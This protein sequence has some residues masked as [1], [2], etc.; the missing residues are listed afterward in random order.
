MRVALTPLLTQLY[1]GAPYSLSRRADPLER[2]TVS[3]K[4]P[5]PI[6][7]TDLADRLS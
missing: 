4:A 5:G 3:V 2:L 7:I 1:P 6:T